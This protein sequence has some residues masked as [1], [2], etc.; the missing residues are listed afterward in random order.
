MIVLIIHFKEEINII[1]MFHIQRN[2]SS[3]YPGGDEIRI[4]DCYGK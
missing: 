1:L 3:Q 4:Y 2:I